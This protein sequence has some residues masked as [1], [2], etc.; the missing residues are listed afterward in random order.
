MRSRPPWRAD[1]RPGATISHQLDHPRV[2]GEM[3]PASKGRSQILGN[4]AEIDAGGARLF[5]D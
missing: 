3:Q 4:D 5:F 1:E 2:V